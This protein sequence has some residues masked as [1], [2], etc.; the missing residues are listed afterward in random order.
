[1]LQAVK[2]NLGSLPERAIADTGYKSRRCSRPW[3]A[4]AAIW[5]WHWAARASGR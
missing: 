5:W 1:M 3:P 4:V 2:A